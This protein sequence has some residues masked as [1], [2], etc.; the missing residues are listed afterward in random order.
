M[1]LDFRGELRGIGVC[2][3]ESDVVLDDPCLRDTEGFRQGMNLNRG[4]FHVRATL[5][6]V[7]IAYSWKIRRVDCEFVLELFN[8][9]PPHS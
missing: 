8:Q 9:G 7:G 5:G 1:L 3:H 4:C 6:D 2:N